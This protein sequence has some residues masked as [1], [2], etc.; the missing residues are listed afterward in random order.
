ME[1][2]IPLSTFSL[3]V[4]NCQNFFFFFLNC[5]AATHTAS[6][7]LFSCSYNVFFFSL[8]TGSF[9]WVYMYRFF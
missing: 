2:E 7:L 6:Y 1:M 9:L 4:T 5:G 8:P 3:F